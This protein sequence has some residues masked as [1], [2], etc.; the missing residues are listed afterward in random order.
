VFYVFMTLRQKVC[1][2]M[3]LTQIERNHSRIRRQ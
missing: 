1:A 2:S 3:E